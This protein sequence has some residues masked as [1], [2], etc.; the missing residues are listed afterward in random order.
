LDELKKQN[1]ISAST[2]ML[3]SDSK[4]EDDEDRSSIIN[5]N[6]SF[7]LD[8]SKG[9]VVREI[10]ENNINA[11]SP[12]V[13]FPSKVSMQKTTDILPSTAILPKL[14]LA[15][16]FA[17]KNQNTRNKATD[18]VQKQEGTSF[19]KNFNTTII[20]KNSVSIQEKELTNKIEQLT[21]ELMASNQKIEEMKNKLEKYKKNYKEMKNKTNKL[22][23][24]LKLAN[25][26][27]E[28]LKMQIK[29]FEKLN[30]KKNIEININESLNELEESSL[31]ISIV[32][33][34][35]N[36]YTERNIAK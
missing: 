24:N 4:I 29:K 30:P 14:D 31:D 25:N 12:R 34:D 5:T 18:V 2:N 16:L 23:E 33:V 35:L 10:Y 9:D 27:I 15:R 20:K 11:D 28:I 13:I 19:I 22:K 6:D 21:K 32:D 36:K 3:D 17:N 26:K 7:S 1:G 8:I